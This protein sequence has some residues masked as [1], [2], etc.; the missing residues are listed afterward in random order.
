MVAGVLRSPAARLSSPS[1]PPLMASHFIL[2]VRDQ[3]RARRFYEE[4]LGRP[5]RLDV[6]G[7]TEFALP[8]GGILGLIPESS[9]RA[10]LGGKIPD[11]AQAHGTPRS[12]LYLV[13]DDPEQRHACA[14]RAGGKE[15][16]GF[17]PRDWGHRAAYCLDPDGHILAFASADREGDP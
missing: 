8:S 7:M 2:Y 17:E 1:H 14:L 9:I 6:P 16:S 15:L 13:V 11:P 5:P 3:E 4:A 10:L 12:E